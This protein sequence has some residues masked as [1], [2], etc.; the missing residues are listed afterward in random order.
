MSEF[1]W[2]YFFIKRYQEDN[3]QKFCR[4]KMNFWK[5]ESYKS[6]VIY[7]NLKTSEYEKLLTL[8]NEEMK[9]LGNTV[10][11]GKQEEQVFGTFSP[12]YNSLITIL[13]IE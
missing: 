10:S 4:T 2:I 9:V 12:D 11:G 13:Y 8:K 5:S 7:H 3:I 1:G 6:N